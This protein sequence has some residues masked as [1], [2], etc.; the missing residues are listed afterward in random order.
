MTEELMVGTVGWDHDDWVGE[1]YPDDL[2]RDWRFGYYS[3]DYRSVL[4]PEDHWPMDHLSLVQEWLADS[5]EEFRFV[6]Q[7][8]S[9]LLAS[10]NTARLDDFLRQIG[11][12]SDRTAGLLLSM[13]HLNIDL[14]AL[15]SILDIVSP[16]AS[17]CVELPESLSASSEA[18]ALLRNTNAGRCWYPA[19][20]P[21]PAAGGALMV[22]ISASGD[23][24]AQR[25]QIELLEHWMQQSGGVAGLFFTG[26]GRAPK[27]ASQA[28]I[29]AEMMGI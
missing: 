14:A 10:V 1:Y 22:A 6:L 28:R 24:K 27:A 2:P 26:G 13:T 7:L 8:P 12:L 19:A 20:E 11:E 17:V 29:I 3:N 9:P 18:D 4:V 16:R 21:A 23:A 25:Q 5:S 15:S